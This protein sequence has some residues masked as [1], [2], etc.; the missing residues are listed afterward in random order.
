VGRPARE[1]GG[2]R[3]GR[4]GGGGH[5]GPGRPSASSACTPAGTTWR[6]G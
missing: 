5:Q 2:G 1:V 3:A 4:G 6:T